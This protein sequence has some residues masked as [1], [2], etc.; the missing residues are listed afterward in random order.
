ML[1]QRQQGK[2]E[3]HITIAWVGF[4]DSNRVQQHVEKECWVFSVR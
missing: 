3:T 4:E 2:R 1:P